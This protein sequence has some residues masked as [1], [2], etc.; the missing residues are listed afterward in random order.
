MIQGVSDGISGGFRVDAGRSRACIPELLIYCYDPA[1]SE[2]FLDRL[3]SSVDRSQNYDVTCVV[4]HA[5]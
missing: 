5:L 3:H 2:R 4:K 1:Y